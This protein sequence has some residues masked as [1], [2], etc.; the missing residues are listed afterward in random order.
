MAQNRRL[1]GAAIGLGVVL[2]LIVI[3]KL[4]RPIFAEHHEIQTSAAAS[5]KGRIVIG[6]DNFVGYF[7]LCSPLMQARML[8]DG[9]TLECRDDQA[10][11]ATRYNSLKT[12]EL[13]LAVGTVDSYEE[14]GRVHGYPATISFVIDRSRGADAIVANSAA[15]TNLDGLKTN[16]NIKVAL[17]SESPS[18]YLLKAI[19]VDFDIPLLRNRAGAWRVPT[20][21]SNEALK[22]LVAGD[23]HVAVLWE[24]DVTK[25]LAL[26]G[27]VKLIGTDQTDKLINDV[28]LV[29]RDFGRDHP[30]VV[31]IVLAN[32]GKTLAYYTDH[33]AELRQ[34]VAK[35]ANVTGEQADI[36]LRGIQWYTLTENA[37]EWF[38]LGNAGSGIPSFGI[39]DV[40]NATAKVLT[41]YYGLTSSPLPNNGDARLIFNSTFVGAL[42]ADEALKTAA[43]QANIDSLARPFSPLSETAWANLKPVGTLKVRPIVFQSGNNQL[44]LAGKQQ[45]DET[46]ETLRTFS[47]YRIRVEGHTKPGGDETANKDLSTERAEAVARYLQVT[48]NIDPN[49]IRVVGFGS[50]RPLTQAQGES[51]STYTGRLPRVDLL[52]LTE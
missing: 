27:M 33:K 12:G 45:I 10:K 28:L 31:K 35:Y 21:G 4:S 15:V 46:V 11:Y 50:K 43:A 34:A 8:A 38:G 25:A 9:Y 48:Y 29:N 3:V 41:D 2:L 49:R 20:D 1:V 32:Y 17:T 39:V 30:D 37:T 6:M 5:S 13:T 40:I 24:P 52:L 7:P 19:A 16:L 14:Y 26:P 22:R 36:M 51:Y 42:Y 23:A 47:G 18:D 44:T